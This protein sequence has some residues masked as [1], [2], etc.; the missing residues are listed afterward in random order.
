[1]K[2]V[3][4][5]SSVKKLFTKCSWVISI[6]VLTCFYKVQDMFL[7]FETFVLKQ[8]L[9]KSKET[10][11]Q[12]R[13]VDIQK[14]VQFK[15]KSIKKDI[16]VLESV[17]HKKNEH[18]MK[19]I[20]HTPLAVTDEIYGIKVQVRGFMY[21][22]DIHVY[23][24]KTK[25]VLLHSTVKKDNCNRYYLDV[26]KTKEVIFLFDNPVVFKYIEFVDLK[27]YNCNEAAV[28][29]IFSAMDEDDRQSDTFISD[30]K[31]IICNTA[32]F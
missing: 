32:V 9:E 5:I 15:L 26:D 8:I 20:M 29:L 14:Y 13:I 10:T 24:N 17:I 25:L 7:Q 22:T 21:F 31:Y 3:K 4:C 27:I 23:D 11:K 12:T 28:S 18:I 30:N 19:C 16:S 2:T 1:M 6:C